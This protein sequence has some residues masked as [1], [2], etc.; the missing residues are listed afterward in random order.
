LK[1]R[2]FKKSSKN[3]NHCYKYIYVDDMIITGYDNEIFSII[4]KI[5]RNFKISKCEPI[6]Y[7][8][9]MKIEK[10]LKTFV[11]TYL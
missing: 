9:G 3:L 7:I 6:K 11:I 8:Q 2:I 1:K 5:I 10:V 4:N